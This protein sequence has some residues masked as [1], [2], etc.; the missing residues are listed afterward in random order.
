MTLSSRQ[1]AQALRVMPGGVSS[2]VRSFKGVGGTPRVIA[3][4]AGA[5]LI[6]VDGL[7]YIDYIGSWGAAIAGHAH[8][9]VVEAVERAVRDGL[10]F[11]TTTAGEAELA[12]RIIDRVPGVEMVRLV[13]SGTEAVMSAV[14]LARGATGRSKVIKFEGGYHGH[15]DALLVRAGSGV[16][17]LALPDS[18]GVP[19]SAI[20]DTLVARYNDPAAV[21]ALFD[22]HPGA[23]AAVVVEPVAGNMGVVAP[24]PG[25]LQTLRETTHRRGALLIFDEVMTG[26]R[27]SRG[28]ASALL[29]VVPDIWVFGKIIG[30]GLPIGA[31]AASRRLMKLIAP[32]GPIYQAGTFSGNP[33]S[34]AGGLSTLDLLDDAAY[35]RLESLSERLHRGLA[36]AL[37]EIDTT[38]FVSRVGSMLTVFLGIQH[39]QNYDDVRAGSPEEFGRWFHG[40]LDRGVHL[41]P[42][43]FESWFVSLAHDESMIDRTIAAARESLL[44]LRTTAT[45]AQPASLPASARRCTSPQLQGPRL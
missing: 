37:R 10:S 26:F 27:V 8:G 3:R 21:E 22:Q 16:A 19:A 31:Y 12:Q 41:P 5:E 18:Q 40:L 20:A 9:H 43:A 24:Q 44:E 13:N 32:A 6:D 15:S 42:G 35:L 17:T 38:G 36:D 29:G 39:A 30:G 4:G 45:S 1:F 2:P 14:R 7:R 33:I 28:G 23:I 34:V 11:G 25:F